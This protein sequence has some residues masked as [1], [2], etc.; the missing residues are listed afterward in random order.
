[1]DK[2]VNQLTESEN[3]IEADPTRIRRVWTLFLSMYGAK[4]VA[5]TKMAVG[6]MYRVVDNVTERE[7]CKDTSR[8]PKLAITSI[9][10]Q[11]ILK[12]VNFIGC[13]RCSMKVSSCWQIT[14]YWSK[15]KSLLYTVLY[16]Y[17]V[18]RQKFVG[19]SE[20][21]CWNAAIYS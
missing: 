18:K 16:S 9:S 6:R 13:V 19:V 20:K 7:N 21:T 15:G 14:N 12:L 3:R 5:I 2:E 11:H 4:N 8:H 1:M 17:T 10:H